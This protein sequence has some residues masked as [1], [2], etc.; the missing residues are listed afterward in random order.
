MVAL[1]ICAFVGHGDKR[2][3]GATV[4]YTDCW[5]AVV[6]PLIFR[7]TSGWKLTRL[8]LGL[9]IVALLEKGDSCVIGNC[10]L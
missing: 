4:E 3:C 2:V 9:V 7:I 6:V 8:D 1:F 10:S 5:G